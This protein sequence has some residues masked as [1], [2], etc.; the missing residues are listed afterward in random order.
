MGAVKIGVLRVKR[1]TGVSRMSSV[2]DRVDLPKI[3]RMHLHDTVV[4]HLRRFITEGVL[5]PGTK[6]SEKDLCETL[7]ISRTPLREALKVLA[8]ERLIELTPNRGARVAILSEVEI[9]EAFEMMGGLEA[10]AGELACA[11]ITDAEIARAEQLHEAM[12]QAKASDDLPSYFRL[13][14]AIH[15]LISLAAG[16]QMLRDTSLGLNRRLQ[17]LRLMSNE[18]SVK[19][20]RAI[21]DHE[22]MLKALKARN[23]KQLALVLR[24]H[25]LDASGLF[26]TGVDTSSG[27]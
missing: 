2:P 11:R 4:E 3:E 1:L 16:N 22:Q 19:W 8:Q 21:R 5:R 14:S 25:L 9:R 12:I 20:D 18:R 26:P 10:F 6:L 23:G 13:N 15:D 17:A 7:G 27:A 24:R